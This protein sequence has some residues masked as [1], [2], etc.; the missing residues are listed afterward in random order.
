[1][2]ADEITLEN[3]RQ[4][5]HIQTDLRGQAET[6]WRAAQRALVGLL[7]TFAPDVVDQRLK[8]GL[9]LDQL[10]VDELEQ[11]LRQTIGSQLNQAQS[12]SR[13]KLSS[14]PDLPRKEIAEKLQEEL[15]KSQDDNAQLAR[16]IHQLE[17]EQTSLMNQL[18]ALQQVR[19]KENIPE[20]KGNAPELPDQV[21]PMTLP[22]EPDWMA[23]WRRAETFERDSG[24]LKMIGETGLARRPLIEAQAAQLLGIKKAG[25]SIQALLARLVDREMLEI[26]KPWSAEGAGTGGRY[27]DLIRLTER[28]NLAFWLLTGRK[29]PVNEYDLL[30]ERHVSPEHTLLNLQAADILQEA[31]YRVDRTPPEIHLP[32]GGLF[33]PDLVLVDSMG[34]TLFV[35]V[36][37][38]ADKNKELRQ[39]KWRNFAQASGGRLYVVCENRASMRAIRSEINFCL[40]SKQLVVSLTNLADLQA[41]KRG[42]GDSIWFEERSRG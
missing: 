2:A 17:T 24:I 37:R 31:G 33:K 35:E 12:A 27:P 34:A 14:K 19:S 21:E 4:L 26:F 22:P 11:M 38:E 13:Q 8:T 5:L 36:E 7:E 23:Q 32:D 1:M 25:G 39:S 20:P 42:D 29:A 28:G 6:K 15:K 16:R 3:L 41:G 9:P 18:S 40:G 10:P 30:L